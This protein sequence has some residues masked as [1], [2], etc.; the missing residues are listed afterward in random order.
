M[1]R[2]QIEQLGEA[3]GREAVAAADA[4]AFLE[5]DGLRR[6]RVREHLVR[7][8]KRLLEADRPAQAMPTDLQEDLVG[9]VVVRAEE[10]SDE[11][12]RKGARLA[13]NVDRL[14]ARGHGSGRDLALDAA[15]GPLDERRDQL[16]GVLQADRRVSAQADAAATLRAPRPELADRERRDRGLLL[17]GA[18]RVAAAH[19]VD[20]VEVHRERGVQRV[21]GLVAV[22]DARDADVGGVVAR[23]EHD[24][25]KRL[26]ADCGD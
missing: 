5:M 18:D 8:L 3:A 16:A 17:G 26:L 21:V 12:L 15:A 7:D 10:Q 24:A 11:D 1:G 6:G 19:G 20:R 14:Q 2:E 23:V 22:L 13:M 4:R 9:D 25:A